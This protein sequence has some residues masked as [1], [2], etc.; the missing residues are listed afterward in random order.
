MKQSIPIQSPIQSTYDNLTTDP[1]NHVKV[2]GV[3]LQLNGDQVHTSGTLGTSCFQKICIEPQFSDSSSTTVGDLWLSTNDDD[4]KTAK[5]MM[6]E[7]RFDKSH[8]DGQLIKRLTG[9][10]LAKSIENCAPVVKIDKC[11]CSALGGSVVCI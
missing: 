3:L 9:D 2:A 5:K 1:S 11:E 10:T 4:V 6:G 7:L 8:I